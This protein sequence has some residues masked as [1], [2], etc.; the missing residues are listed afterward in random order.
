MLTANEASVLSLVWLLEEHSFFKLISP[1]FQ[2]EFILSET[3]L[4]YRLWGLC[5]YL[6]KCRYLMTID[7]WLVNQVVPL[8]DIISPTRGGRELNHLK[9]KKKQQPLCAEFGAQQVFPQ[10]K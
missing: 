8:N 9:L 10:K 6:S 4:F 1:H 5:R 3:M 7:G 2:V